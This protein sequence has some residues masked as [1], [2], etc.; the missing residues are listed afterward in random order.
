MKNQ[1]TRLEEEVKTMRTLVAHMMNANR[2][3]PMP[4]PPTVAYPND[5]LFTRQNSGSTM[6][7]SSQNRHSFGGNFNSQSNENLYANETDLK[8]PIYE[9]G[10]DGHPINGAYGT[11]ADGTLVQMEKDNL[12]LRRELQDALAN[13][14]NADRKIQT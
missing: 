4:P 14:K 3:N 5:M 6:R 10:L 13:K 2:M 11:L 7:N 12:E 8:E 9:N 1:M